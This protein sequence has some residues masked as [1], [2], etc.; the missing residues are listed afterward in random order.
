M[1]EVSNGSCCLSSSDLLANDG[2]NDSLT[3]IDPE[4]N[5]SGVGFVP[6]GENTD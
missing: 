4:P 2:L 1:L 5:G 6:G 3:F